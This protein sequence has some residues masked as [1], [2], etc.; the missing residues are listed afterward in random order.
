MPDIAKTIE[1]V[2]PARKMAAAD[3]KFVDPIG[4]IYKGVS[5]TQ[6][7]K[8]EYLAKW[9]EPTPPPPRKTNRGQN[10]GGSFSWGARGSGGGR[11]GM[12]SRGR[13]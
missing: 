2:Q 4:R 10:R 3:V 7:E 12:P 11:S 8:Q 5:S 13:W 1:D 6:Q 9:D